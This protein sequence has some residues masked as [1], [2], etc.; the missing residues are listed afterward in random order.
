MKA[1]LFK[2]ILLA[3]MLYGMAA[4]AQ[5]ANDSCKAKIWSKFPIADT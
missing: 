4:N 2:T 1:R 3:S 5:E